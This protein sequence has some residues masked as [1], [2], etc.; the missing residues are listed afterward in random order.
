MFNEGVVDLDLHCV[1]SHLPQQGRLQQ[2]P[3]RYKISLERRVAAMQLHTPRSHPAFPHRQG[4]LGGT[5]EVL[6]VLQITEFLEHLN[7]L[8]KIQSQ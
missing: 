7:F 2:E 5:E 4:E 6:K 3:V 1:S 8:P